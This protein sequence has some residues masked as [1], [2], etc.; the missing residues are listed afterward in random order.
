MQ[1]SSPD[2]LLLVAR[3]GDNLRHRSHAPPLLRTFPAGSAHR[4]EQLERPLVRGRP[5]HTA[6]ALAPGAPSPGGGSRGDLPPHFPC[7]GRG[8][9]WREGACAP[10]PR[11]CV[12]PQ[13]S[14]RLGASD[15]AG[16]ILCE[17]PHGLPGTQRPAPRRRPA[18]AGPAAGLP[19]GLQDPR[20]KHPQSKPPPHFPRE[21][22]G[23]CR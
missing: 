14:S 4:Q 8:S 19:S 16:G 5:R 20:L 3:G 11:L 9:R 13:S 22:L 15:S 1:G 23:G 6:P 7:Q 2:L 17:G 21:T 18:L 12:W 10:C